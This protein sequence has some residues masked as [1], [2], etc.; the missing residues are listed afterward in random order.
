MTKS[1]TFQIYL[2]YIT[3]DEKSIIAEE[4]KKLLAKGD[5]GKMGGKNLYDFIST[6]QPLQGKKQTILNFKHLNK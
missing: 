3:E 5:N 6:V 1:T 4:I 2:Y